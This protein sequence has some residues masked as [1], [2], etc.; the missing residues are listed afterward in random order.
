MCLFICALRGWVDTGSIYPL[1]V[2]LLWS[3]ATV[4]IVRWLLFCRSFFGFSSFAN[5][6]R[7]LYAFITHF[8]GGM[9]TSSIQFWASVPCPVCTQAI[10]FKCLVLLRFNKFAVFEHG[11]LL[12]SAYKPFGKAFVAFYFH[13]VLSINKSLSTLLHFCMIAEQP[14]NR[15]AKTLCDHKQASQRPA[16]WVLIVF[17]ERRTVYTRALAFAK[18]YFWHFCP[19]CWPRGKAPQRTQSTLCRACCRASYNGL[20]PMLSV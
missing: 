14:L 11:V 20:P 15:Y 16:L 3:W 19:P 6:Y 13:H 18:Y 12:A 10:D 4:L 1:C 2:L 17:A 7:S 8:T 5:Q 9:N